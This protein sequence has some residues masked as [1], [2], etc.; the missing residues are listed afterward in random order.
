VGTALGSDYRRLWSASAVSNLADGVFQTALPLFALTLT[1]SPTAIAG[2]TL[3]ARLP[4]LLFALHAGALAD[5]LDRR[6]TMVTV[7]V[8]RVVLLVGLAL[9]VVAGR[10]HL[11]VLYLVAFC[12]GVGETLF[13]TSAQSVLPMVVGRDDLSVANGR[14]YAAELTMNQFV[15]PPVGGLLAGSAV[16]LA[17]A[18]SGACY[19]VAA[20]ALVTMTGQFRPTRPDGPPTRLRSDIVEGARFLWRNRLLRQLALM[21]GAMNLVATASIAVL[22]L[23][24]VRPGPM[25]L[26]DHGYGLLLTAGAAGSLLGAFAVP[27]LE[28][29]LGRARVL[30]VSVAGGTIGS[31]APLLVR[32]SLVAVGM[33]VG[34]TMMMGWNIVTVSLRQR[35]TP[36]HLLGRVNAGY[37]LLAWGTIPIGAAVGGA[38]AQAFG[39]RS[40][41]V[42]ATVAEALTLLV[43]TRI[44]D[45][46]ITGAERA[47]DAAAVA[48]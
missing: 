33:V 48:A 29:R 30:V 1:R 46:V 47:A 10:E 3:A 17:F 35:I 14:L 22:P 31:A 40:V 9:V 13:D 19:L 23:F 25:G 28:R 43:A 37:R 39:V 27:R 11:A 41:F 32:P 20:V 24:A 4:W 6:R 2:L 36:E 18:G 5:R 34:G 42:L 12:L 21:V 8:A 7:D 45:D 26:S 16:A 15:G 38:V 44:T